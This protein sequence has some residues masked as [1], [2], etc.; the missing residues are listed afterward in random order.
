M[1]DI[2][3]P[4][5]PGDSGATPVTTTPAAAPAAAP[6]PPSKA[7]SQKTSF[8]DALSKI[9]EFKPAEKAK[10]TPQDEPEA[11]EAVKTPSV[12]PD[13]DSAKQAPK[14]KGS[15]AHEQF[16]KL[17]NDLKAARDEKA[18]L[19]TKIKD[20]ESRG[21]NTDALEAERE[22]LRKELDATKAQ[23]AQ[24][25]PAVTKEFQEK[26]DVPFK[27]ERDEA[28]ASVEAF[29]T[30]NPDTGEFDG[31]PAKWEEFTAIFG[32][33]T[34]LAAIAIQRKWG[35]YAPIV[36]NHVIALRRI[37]TGRD[38]AL[39]DSSKIAE[40]KFKESEAQRQANEKLVSDSLTQFN[41]ETIDANPELYNMAPA[42]ED[43]EGNAALQEGIKEVGNRGNTPQEYAK[44]LSTVQ[45]RAAAFPRVELRLKRATAKVAE[46]E[47]VIEKMKGLAVGKGGKPIATAEAPKSKGLMAGLKDLA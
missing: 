35:P 34:N 30:V 6:A 14:A 3:M 22:T 11:V 44:W 29:P 37:Q 7:A 43:D 42:G 36:M 19:E 20:Y 2:N 18:A 25:N 8:A 15:I 12:A 9:P 28:Q 27:K 1:P 5:L 40:T 32:Q 47:G 23:L 4:T 31:P 16:E 45:L 17:G 21:K 10:E 39:A 24:Y 13:A 46:L 41:R 33:P 38:A 26:Y